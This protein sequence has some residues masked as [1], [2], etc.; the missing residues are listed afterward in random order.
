METEEINKINVFFAKFL[1]Y[2]Y[3]TKNNHNRNYGWML[4]YNFF[5]HISNKGYHYMYAEIGNTNFIGYS[6]YKSLYFN[7]RYNWLLPVV[8]KCY[9]L[10]LSCKL[11][12]YVF[13]IE[14][15]YK[16]TYLYLKNEF[17]EIN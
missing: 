1:G 13:D 8:K 5:Y 9:E 16:E 14:K 10:D 2:T 3:H 12:N 15:L 17:K 11:I 7:T 6:Y 4:R